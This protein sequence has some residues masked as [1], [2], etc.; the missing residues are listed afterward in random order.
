VSGLD[1]QALAQPGIRALR[2]YDPGHDL[3][4]LRAGCTG[5][6]LLELGS[7]ENP[8]G[9]SP[10]ARQA[11][12]DALGGVHLYPDPLGG[13]LKRALA[14]HHGI[15]T[16]G[17]LL[18]NGSHELLMQF[19]QV[20]AGP[21]EEVVASAFGF[22]VYALAAQAAGARLRLASALPR[23]H[24]MPRGHDLAA[25]LEAIGPRTKLVYLANPNN[26]TGTWFGA[27]AF[28]QCLARVPE[29][30][31][32]VVDEAYAEFA[33]APDYA[34]ALPLVPRHPNLVVTRTF[35]KAYAL[36]GLRVGYAVAHPQ[37]I[38][39]MERV[40][41]SFNVNAL[42][43]AAAQSALADGA[44]LA[45]SVAANAQ[46]RA[47]L[48]QALQARGWSVSPSQTN[49]LLVELGPDASRIETALLARGVVLRP[50]GGYGLPECLRI[51]VGT[52]GQNARLLA[53]LDEVAR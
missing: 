19:A 5:K 9:A 52:E 13:E 51:T 36:A 46:Q 37:L 42:G 31:I 10:K 4:A 26:P 1:V 11:I 44:H 28:A 45:Q 23:E 49:F 30:V 18:G 41:E 48:A 2:A 25:V 3:V 14:S 7:N 20:F 53:A 21:G 24:A 12:I 50:M 32:V 22:A 34:S 40:R 17:L 16:A 47:A 8:H 27:D 38:A 15:A 35:S 43:L 33:D 39:V 29:Q 6:P